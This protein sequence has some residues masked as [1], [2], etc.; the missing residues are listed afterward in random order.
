MPL[1]TRIDNVEL[2]AEEFTVHFEIWLA[3]LIDTLN[4]DLDLLQRSIS[5]G[6]V[7]LIAG[8]ATVLA[9]INTGDDVFLNLTNA[10][11]PGFISTSINDGVSFT[12]TSSN[13]ADAST[14]S[15]MIVKF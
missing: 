1:L 10:V 15:Y 2:S 3:N 6:T 8:T 5:R 7:T 14:F 11:N 4:E 13:G 12:L 9:N